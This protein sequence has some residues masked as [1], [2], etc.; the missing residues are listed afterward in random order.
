MHYV[1]KRVIVALCLAMLIPA[2]SAPAQTGNFP[3]KPVSVVLPYPSGSINIVMQV[4]TDRMSQVLG[5]P[6]VPINKPGG[7]TA[8]GTVFVA[9]SK[10][11]G[12]TL[13][14]S[15]GAFI[16]LPLTMASPPYKLSDFIPIGRITTGDFLLVT[17]KNLPV[18]NL[19]EF[20]AYARKNPGKLSFAAGSAGSLPRLG[21]ELFKE[22]AGID[23]QYI[24]YSGPDQSVPALL[25][26]HIHYGLMEARPNIN[27]VKSG[28]MKALAIFSAKR[29]TTYFPNIPT[30]VEEGYPDVVTYTFFAMYAP[31][32][33]PAPVVKKLEAALKEAAMDKDVQQRLDKAEFR[34][35]YLNSDQTKAWLQGEERKWADVIKR[36]KIQFNE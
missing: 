15:S 21:A 7:G 25:G 24:P 14:T 3:N 29:D 22:R 1:V 27:Y 8:V 5:K 23:A 33:T 36:L 12:Y 31:A 35:D 4:I 9:T 26:G 6:V 28:E 19:K 20:V 30:L 2:M 32:K 18:K 34:I 10:P 16:S 13:L 17:N 11:D